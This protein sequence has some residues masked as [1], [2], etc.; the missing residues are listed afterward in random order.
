MEFNDYKSLEESGARFVEKL[1][2]KGTKHISQRILCNGENYVLKKFRSESEAIRESKAHEIL[3]EQTDLLLPRKIFRDR[4]VILYE[5]ILEL[6]ECTPIEMIEDWQ[7][8]HINNELANYFEVEN[9]RAE[10]IEWLAGKIIERGDLYG[11]NRGEYSRIIKIGI[12]DLVN[13]PELGVVHGDLHLGNVIVRG[14]FR[15]YIDLE[16][17]AVK[18]PITDLVP[19]VLNHLDW[20]DRLVQYYCGITG[21]DEGAVKRRLTT[22]SMFRGTKLMGYQDNRNIK[23]EIKLKARRRIIKSLDS[24]L[25]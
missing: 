17:C 1:G 23:K 3:S 14:G 16:T 22:L 8:I 15:F 11:K 24:L 4:E 5:Y 9:P 21:A 6:G 20:K 13:P 7:K 19:T 18:D 25:E 10:Y 12:S 2:R